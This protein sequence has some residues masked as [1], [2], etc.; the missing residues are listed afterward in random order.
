[1]NGNEKNMKKCSFISVYFS[2]V[3]IKRI[4]K[5]SQ[6][7]GVSKSRLVEQAFLLGF[8]RLLNVYGIKEEELNED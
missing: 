1:M 6:I 8:D 5:I 4:E 3:L 2:D 7:T